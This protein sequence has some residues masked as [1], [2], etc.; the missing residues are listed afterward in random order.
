MPYI[1]KSSVPLIA[2]AATSLKHKQDAKVVT[3]SIDNDSFAKDLA[4]V[5]KDK[6]G[7]RHV[8][9]IYRNNDRYSRDMAEFFAKYFDAIDG[10]TLKLGFHKVD[11]RLIENLEANLRP[12]T[13][14]YLPIFKQDIIPLTSK[15][16]AKQISQQILGS[17]SWDVSYLSQFSFLEGAIV[18]QS[19]AP[20]RTP[21]AK[22]IEFLSRYR[23][24]NHRD[25]IPTEVLTEDAMNYIRHIMCAH[26]NF[27]P[28]LFARFLAQSTAYTGI[29]GIIT[30]Q[31]SK[32]RVHRPSYVIIEKGGALPWPI[33]N[34]EIDD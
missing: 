12:D 2:I 13:V 30:P 27:R 20:S 6:L 3:L 22:E 16:A 21:S 18:A 34:G 4:E 28:E 1:E 23:S 17:D 7:S 26:K 33:E 31:S 29:S 9:V 8:V 25:P 15:L 10:E 14:I 11:D 5:A 24:Q 19:W 32:G